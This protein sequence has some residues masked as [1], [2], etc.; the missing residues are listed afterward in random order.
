MPRTV[1]LVVRVGKSGKA[2]LRALTHA[3][4]EKRRQPATGFA[5]LAETLA[6]VATAW[7]A[8]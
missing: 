2:C 5:V 1:D 4:D 6:E 3:S 8:R 7:V